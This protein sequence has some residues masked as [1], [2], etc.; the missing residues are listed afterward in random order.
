M[1]GTSDKTRLAHN[2]KRFPCRALPGAG[3]DDIIGK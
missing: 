1:D 2:M 3:L